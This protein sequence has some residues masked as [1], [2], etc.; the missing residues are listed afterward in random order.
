VEPKKHKVFP[1]NLSIPRR[2]TGAGFRTEHSR[3]CVL[4]DEGEKRQRIKLRL[5]EILDENDEFTQKNMHA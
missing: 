4:Y 3:F 1:Q 5:G 2:R